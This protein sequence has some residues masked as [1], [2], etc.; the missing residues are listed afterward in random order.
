M[1][2]KLQN[3]F[4]KYSP[5]EYAMILLAAIVGNYVFTKIKPPKIFNIFF[6]TLSMDIFFA[7]INQNNAL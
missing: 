5:L 2:K 6:L 4:S 7:K 1:V 3:L